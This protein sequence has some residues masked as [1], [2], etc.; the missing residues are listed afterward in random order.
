MDLE[1]IELRSLHISF[2]AVQAER[3]DQYVPPKKGN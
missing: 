1:L 3:M 2:E